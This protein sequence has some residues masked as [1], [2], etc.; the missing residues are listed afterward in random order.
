M[1]CEVPIAASRLPVLKEVGEE[2]VLFFNPD[3]VNSIE[4]ALKNIITDDR[5]RKS[6]IEKGKAR[7]K[8]FSWEKCARETLAEINNL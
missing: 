3:D 5:L 6:L 1:A 7:V 4:E 2:A 8:N